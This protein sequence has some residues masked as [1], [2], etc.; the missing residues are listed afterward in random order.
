[1][2]AKVILNPYSNRWI[3]QKR[4]PEAEKAL[5][6]AG[7]DFDL[8]VSEY[9]HHLIDLA[10][11]ASEKGFSPIIAA[12]GDG[13]IGDVVNGL[14][15]ASKTE[16]ALLG[17]LGIMPLGSANDLVDNLKI[18]KDLGEAAKV[19]AAGKVKKMDIGC[20]NGFYFANNSAIG[21]EPYITLKQEKITSI[22]G[23]ARYLV[24]TVQG[25]WDN[26]QW[27]ASIEWDDGKFD[28]PVLLVSVGNAPRTG[29]VFFMAPH[30]DPFDGKLTFVHGYRKTR[31]QIFKLLPKTMKPAEGSYVEM[32]GVQ[33]HF[34]TWINIKVDRPTP[35]HTDGEIFST[36][37]Q[38]FEY[39]IFPEKLNILLP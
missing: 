34:A 9:P 20:V 32:E 19:I 21:L 35:A 4:W 36:E 3:S 29:G 10:C 26:P 6:E 28:G 22:K 1:M 33:E 15:K 2:K 14:A 11:E 30:A 13:T 7:I 17:P 23:I 24:A 37:D 12:G 39:R 16:T 31:G 5:H 18:P 8:E 25:I 27:K 38:E